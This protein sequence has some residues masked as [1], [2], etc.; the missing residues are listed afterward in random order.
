[1]T[2]SIRYFQIVE[3]CK[4]DIAEIIP[5]FPK[6]GTIEQWEAYLEELERIEEEPHEHVEC[7]QHWDWAIYTHFGWKILAGLPQEIER[8]AEAYF[9]DCYGSEPISTLSDCY[10]MAAKIALFALEIIF[11]ETL[12]E[13]VAELKELAQDQIDNLESE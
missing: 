10:D 13:T 6:T 12:Q 5:S 8:Q 7:I 9:F 1:M 2:D 3:R 4:V 11:T